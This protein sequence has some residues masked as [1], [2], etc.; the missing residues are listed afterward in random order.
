MG[1]EKEELIRCRVDDLFNT[2]LELGLRALVALDSLAPEALDLDA[3]TQYEYV[4]VHSAEIDGG[5]ASLHP[6]TPMVR[7]E[8]LSHRRI[9]EQGLELLFAKGLV[10]KSFEQTGMTYKAS[11]LAGRFLAHMRSSYAGALLERGM[12]LRDVAHRGHTSRLRADL[13]ALLAENTTDKDV[14]YLGE[15]EA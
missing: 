5:P 4:L 14:L 13:K 9:L 7:G 15:D 1:T 8:F 11:P 6:R 10:V 2:P 3:V 12:W